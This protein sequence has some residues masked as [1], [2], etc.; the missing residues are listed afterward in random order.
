MEL[1]RA[2]FSLIVEP[3]STKATQL[4]ALFSRPRF[5]DAQRASADVFTVELRNGR[6]GFALVRHLDEAEAA[7]AARLAI[8]EDL[9][10]RNF[11]KRTE[12]IAKLVFAHAIRQIANVD[13]HHPALTPLRT[14]DRRSTNGVSSSAAA[15]LY[16][17]R[18]GAVNAEILPISRT[19]AAEAV[20]VCRAGA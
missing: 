7:R 19:F 12:S 5:V 15:K 20:S 14:P 16:G 13:I 18:F 10:G 11:T 6:F 9:D 8:H 3:R 4:A 2:V 17:R 1:R